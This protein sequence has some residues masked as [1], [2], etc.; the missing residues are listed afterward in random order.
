MALFPAIIANTFKSLSL[1]TL[2]VVLLSSLRLCNFLVSLRLCSSLVASSFVTIVSTFGRRP[3][4]ALTFTCTAVIKLLY[5]G[6]NPWII[7]L[8]IRDSTMAE[9]GS[10]LVI[11]RQIDLALWK[12]EQSS[13]HVVKLTTTHSPKVV[14]SYRSSLRTTS[15]T[16]PMLL[17]VSCHHNMF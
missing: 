17:L 13:C 3:I 11:S 7:I 8:V 2:I 9:F 1:K 15:R 12:Y 5:S 6:H 4:I 16:C 14:A 10:S